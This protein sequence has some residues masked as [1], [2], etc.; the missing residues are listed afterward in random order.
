MRRHEETRTL[1][2]TVSG[3]PATYKNFRSTTP[4]IAKNLLELNNIEQ[5][6]VTH[7]E[8][9][10]MTKEEEFIAAPVSSSSN[11]LRLSVDAGVGLFMDGPWYTQAE[12]SCWH[13]ELSYENE[14]YR[15]RTYK[16]ISARPSATY[17][18]GMFGIGL[19]L[20][21][22]FGFGAHLEVSSPSGSFEQ[23]F[24]VGV[25]TGGVYPNVLMS[26]AYNLDYLMADVWLIGFGLSLWNRFE[27][28]IEPWEAFY[29]VSLRLGYS[30][31]L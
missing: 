25:A 14:C 11:Q 22:D 7:L 20:E 13:D 24:Q 15:H 3:Y 8:A 10:Q 4:E 30:F 21:N 9:A 31:H 18:F 29:L 27:Y 26:L 16:N 1:K 12:Q 17:R 28:M 19:G 2:L 5:G 6:V 23:N